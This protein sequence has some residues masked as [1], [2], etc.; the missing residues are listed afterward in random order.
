MWESRRLGGVVREAQ[1]ERQVIQMS[2]GTTE[3]KKTPKKAPKKAAK[4]AVK[5]TKKGGKK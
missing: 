3:S 5:K 4:K 1:T 2:T